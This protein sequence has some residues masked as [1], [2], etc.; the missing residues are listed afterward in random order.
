MPKMKSRATAKKRFKKLGS[1]LVK[2]AK[3]Y[4]RK[5]LTNKTRKVKRNLRRVAYV[6]DSQLRSVIQL[7]ASR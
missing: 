2:R 3:A 4:R 1:G 5:K 7:L 6:D